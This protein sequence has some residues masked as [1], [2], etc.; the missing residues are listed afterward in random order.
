MLTLSKNDVCCIL[1][2]EQQRSEDSVHNAA[3]RHSTALQRTRVSCPRV[4][5]RLRTLVRACARAQR[6][7][8]QRVTIHPPAATQDGSLD[9]L[10]HALAAILVRRLSAEQHP[11]TAPR[12]EPP[13]R[14]TTR[15]HD[16]THRHLCPSE[17]RRTD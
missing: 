8:L 5:A 13:A 10:I 12:P 16:E 9:D 1:Y 15:G 4:G 11:A 17:H 3:R 14:T 7:E 6:P 2:V